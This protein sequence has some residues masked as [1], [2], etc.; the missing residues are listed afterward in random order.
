[1][2][3]ASSGVL[4]DL[5]RFQKEKEEDLKRYMVI[6]NTA[7][8]YPA[9]LTLS[10]SDCV[11]KMSY[12]MGKKELGGLG[13][14]SGRSGQNRALVDSA[15]SSLYPI[16]T[17]IRDDFDDFFLHYTGDYSIESIGP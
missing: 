11:C 16:P 9:S 12:R 8:L 4:K 13:G 1:M 17:E 14:S 5:K 10:M 7:S 15:N 6:L 3:D 2:K